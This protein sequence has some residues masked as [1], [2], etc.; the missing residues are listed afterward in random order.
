MIK[1]AFLFVFVLVTASAASGQSAGSLAQVASGGG[2][3]T[4]FTIASQDTTTVN[5][6]LEFY[7]DNGTPLALPLSFPQTGSGATTT[8]SLDRTLA[9]GASLLVDAGGGAQQITG[10]AKFTATGNATGF[11]IFSFPGLGWNAVV[12]LETRG[13][14]TY[15][16]AF[17]NVGALGTGVAIA[18]TAAVAGSVAAVI[19]DDT[20]ATLSSPTISLPASGHQSFLLSDAYPVTKGKRGVIR[21]TGS[22]ISVL[23]LRANG[24]ALTTLPALVTGSPGNSSITHVTFNGGFTTRF[25]LVNTGSSQSPTSLSFFDDRGAALSVPMSLPQTGET[26]T[27]TTITRFLA[28]GASLLIDTVA[29]DSLASV[30]GSAQMS[31]G[32]LSS[33]FAIFR[34]TTFGQEASVP[35]ET[36]NPAAF[37]LAFDNTGGLTTGIALNNI[38][39]Q[40]QSVPVVIRDDAG[41]VLG[42]GIVALASGGHTSFLLPDKFS[43]A[44]NNRGTAEF[45][46]PAN[47]Q[48]SAIGLRAKSDGTLT[49]VPVFTG[50][51]QSPFFTSQAPY[52]L[53]PQGPVP[54]TMPD[55]TVVANGSNQI[56]VFLK[57]GVTA[58]QMQ[59]VAAVISAAGAT[60]VGQAPRLQ[61]LQVQLPD[62]SNIATLM[63][64]LQTTAG[65]LFVGP[66]LFLVRGGCNSTTDCASV[67]PGT[68]GDNWVG[69]MNLPVPPTSSNGVVMY[70]FDCF[71]PVRCLD[72]GNKYTHG[73]LTGAFLQRAAGSAIPMI[74]VDLAAYMDAKGRIDMQIAVEKAFDLLLVDAIAHPERKYVLNWSWVVDCFGAT[75]LDQDVDGESWVY[76]DLIAAVKLASALYGD[77]FL[78]VKSAGNASVALPP[79]PD[80]TSCN[81]VPVGGLD[82]SATASLAPFS[83]FGSV[84]PANAPACRVNPD[85]ARFTGTVD[86]TSFSGPMVG[87]AMAAEWARRGSNFTACQLTQGLQGVPKPGPGKIP[88][89]DGK[90]AQ[91]YL[92]SHPSGSTSR[93][94]SCSS[95]SV[96]PKSLVLS[97]SDIKDL[98]IDTVPPG[99]VTDFQV[100]SSDSFVAGVL[101][102]T[103][104]G[105]HPGSATITVGAPPVVACSALVNVVVSPATYKGTLTGVFIDTDPNP[106]AIP[107]TL[108]T[109]ERFTEIPITLS[110][111]F[112]ENGTGA[113]GG[114]GTVGPGS[115][116]LTIPG[117]T[118][119]VGTINVPVSE[120]VTTVTF[121]IQSGS[122]TGTIL[123]DRNLNEVV[124]L[125]VPQIGKMRGTRNETGMTLSI[126][127]TYPT[128]TGTETSRFTA[129]L[130]K[131]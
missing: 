119:V 126:N 50:T 72:S 46:T 129:T 15:L 110:I 63:V 91:T 34:W 28:P 26:I 82:S 104:V 21:L 47:G 9:P 22:S 12:P 44:A 27:A 48:I 121:P 7:A 23:G 69:S 92:T 78:V 111:G 93:D 1:T 4:R 45:D 88:V 86:G 5:I 75:S 83:T 101:N 97:A 131:Q 115:Y 107:N 25:T 29:Q 118:L 123:R 56:I 109:E 120:S 10:W 13:A 57:A 11:A 74:P 130:T 39:N 38:A 127:E 53:P 117:Y 60:V 96:S 17:D 51:P 80:L 2:W 76:R 14:S 73:E 31:T 116:K 32:A 61:E 8:A 37:V 49:T 79:T 16:V 103:V 105:G 81:F 20:G 71:D 36:R 3:T 55:G 24:A 64:Q 52:S 41:V 89:Y 30:S 125:Q 99:L 122:V 18:N 95:I 87:G 84:I 43:A 67:P 77:R 113:V 98:T 35:L 114:N 90:A 54:I 6:H 128:S 124:E 19:T 68:P 66:N 85:P 108:T 100:I 94:L 33:G 65:V 59:A 42:S 112:P 102:K 40:P 58:A 70:D 106:G 62:P